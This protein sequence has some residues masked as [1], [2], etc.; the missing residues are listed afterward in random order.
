MIEKLK[1]ALFNIP[2]YSIYRKYFET[3]DQ[4]KIYYHNVIVMATNNE[5]LVYYD[6]EEHFVTKN[7]KYVDR[8]NTLKSFDNISSAIDYM[9]YLSLVTS[10]I[11]YAQYHYFFFKMKKTEMNYNY[12]S[13]GLAGGFPSPSEEDLVIRC[14]IG[15]LSIKGK[16]VRY[17]LIVIFKNDNSCK[18][19]FYPEQPAWNEG[20]TCPE[21]DVDK[22]IGY[23]LNLKV[24]NYKDIP[25]IES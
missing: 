6:S 9:N 11:R 20:K 18:L 15:D 8:D 24:D 13:F 12:C 25:L 19:S 17:N 16:K 4:I 5:V 10:D 23:V 1:F 3:H 7:L 14:D 2:G 21:T 22:I